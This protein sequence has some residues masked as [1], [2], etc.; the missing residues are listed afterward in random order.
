MY[1]STIKT[2]TEKKVS[3]KENITENMV[4]IIFETKNNGK[5]KTE[6]ITLVGPGTLKSAALV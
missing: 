1:K 3:T 4:S 2:I 5:T 6:T